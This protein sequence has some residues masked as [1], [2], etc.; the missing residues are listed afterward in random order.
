[1]RNS[2]ANVSKISAGVVQSTEFRHEMRFEYLFVFNNILHTKFFRTFNTSKILA[3]VSLIKNTQNSCL[4]V[5]D[6]T[7]QKK[8]CMSNMG[9]E[10]GKNRFNRK[11][12]TSFA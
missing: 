10:K 9:K 11:K 12:P 8:I 7:M 6:G 5:M 3:L 2:S 4:V 1:M